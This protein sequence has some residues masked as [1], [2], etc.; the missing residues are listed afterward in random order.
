[1]KTF[2]AYEVHINDRNVCGISKHT[3]VNIERNDQ[4]TIIAK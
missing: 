3:S 1:M 2:N 4:P